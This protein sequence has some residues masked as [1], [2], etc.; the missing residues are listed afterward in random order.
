MDYIG[1]HSHNHT[2]CTRHP[3]RITKPIVSITRE[4]LKK[5]KTTF[6]GNIVI[7]YMRLLLNENKHKIQNEK[8]FTTQVDRIVTMANHSAVT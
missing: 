1:Q 2:R 5:W 7:V 8:Q 6:R 4:M 3:Q